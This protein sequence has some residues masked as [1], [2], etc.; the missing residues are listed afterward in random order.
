MNISKPLIDWYLAHKRDL[1]WRLTKN[2]YL[3]WLSEIILQQ[4]RVAQGLPYYNAFVSAYPTIDM[5]ANASEDEVLK[6]WQ[7]LGY[8][9]RARNLHA[10][11]KTITD[12]YGGQFPTTYTE[13]LALK[14][15]GSY[16]AA[17]I[18]S[19]SY[20]Q[21]YAVL[22]GNVFRVLSRFF[23][24][25]TPINSSPAKKIFTEIAQQFL[26]KTTPDLYN[27]AIM[28]LGAT[29]CTPTNPT[30]E[31]CPLSDSCVANKKNDVTSLPIKLKKNKVKKRYFN[32]LV[33]QYQEQTVI[34]K[35]LEQDI[36]K[37]LYQFPLI[38]TE[39][40]VEGDEI[41]S[42][43]QQQYHLPDMTIVNVVKYPKHILSHQHIFSTFLFVELKNLKTLENHNWVDVKLLKRFPV[44]KNIDRFLNSYS[45][46]S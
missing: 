32:Y 4:T 33:F 37:G 3:I 40:D 16:T 30:C 34:E 6:L 42:L 28:E 13:V 25:D 45:V 20:N 17:A 7:G 23:W 46:F 26:C 9:S 39:L 18:C 21:P 35:R 29:I 27:Q 36:W 44:S 19:F 8:Y 12:N 24:I 14:G 43:I 41:I 5:L 11:A 31:A 2:P 15:I 22:D 10:T 38:E 1:P